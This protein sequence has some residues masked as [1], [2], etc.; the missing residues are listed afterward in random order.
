MAGGAAAVAWS[1]ER[2]HPLWFDEPCP[3]TN[4][5]TIKKISEETGD[6][7]W[8]RARHPR[9]ED[10]PGSVAGR[11][12][13]YLAA[14]SAPRR[15]YTHPP[16]GHDGGDLLHRCGSAPR[17]RPGRNRGPSALSGE[18]AEFFIQEIPWPADERDRRMRTE[19]VSQPAETV[20]DRFAALPTGSG[21]G[22]E[23]NESALEKYKETAA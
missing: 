12:G 8:I 23:V 1:L 17:Q 5:R 15:H 3:A 6:A 9:G 11:T 19:L 16:G 13:G 21:L 7:S 4:L 14:Q 18:P 20:K 2:F 22:I 10:L